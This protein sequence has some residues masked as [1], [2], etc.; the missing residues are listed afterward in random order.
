[1]KLYLVRH[2]EAA[3]KSAGRERQ[4]T[5][6]GRRD[7][8]A[9]AALLRPMKLKVEAIWHSGKARAGQ[10]AQPLAEALRA[11]QGLQRCDGLMPLDPVKPIAALVGGMSEDLMIVGHEPF[12]GKLAARLLRGRK[13]PSV[14]D[15]GKPGV[16]CL[17]GGGAAWRIAWMLSPELIAAAAEGRPR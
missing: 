16:V 15:L 9:L 2:A 10:T 14:L 1:M 7:A 11:A 3:A 4:L 8:E 17:Q 12:L 5:R 13:S 6:Q